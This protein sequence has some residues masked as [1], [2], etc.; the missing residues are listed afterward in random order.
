[1]DHSNKIDYINETIRKNDI[2]YKNNKKKI[3][4]WII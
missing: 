4:K 2:K 3:K 1:M